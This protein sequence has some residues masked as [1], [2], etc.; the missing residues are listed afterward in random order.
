M[1]KDGTKHEQDIARAAC[2]DAATLSLDAATLSLDAAT[3]S[4]LLFR[5][6]LVADDVVVDANVVLG[7]TERPHIPEECTTNSFCFLCSTMAAESHAPK[8]FGWTLSHFLFVLQPSPPWPRTEQST[9]RISYGPPVATPPPC[10]S[11]CCYFVR[12]LATD[13]VVVVHDAVVLGGTWP[14]YSRRPRCRP[15]VLAWNNMVR[16][17]CRCQANVEHNK[18]RVCDTS[19][20]L[21]CKGRKETDRH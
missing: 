5:A 8:V 9:S 16:S 1:A 10:R 19:D 14:H 4:L 12:L 7:D 2:G 13:D 21:L 20:E 17:S 11:H 15:S 3:L 6:L 18:H